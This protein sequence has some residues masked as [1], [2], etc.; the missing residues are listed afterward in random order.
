[1]ETTVKTSMNSFFFYFW[2]VI[3]GM[4]FILSGALA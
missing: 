2:L 4:I 3:M 1:M